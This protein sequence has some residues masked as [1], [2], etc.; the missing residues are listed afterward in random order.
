M[1]TVV[2]VDGCRAGWFAVALD[3]QGGW[4]VEV[5]SG[6]LELWEEHRGAAHI[7]VDIPI[8]LVSG[9]PMERICDR[10]AR[11]LLGFPRRTSVFPAPCR[12]ALVASDHA[13]ANR[14]NRTRT[15]R[16]LSIQAWGIVPSIVEVDRVL[17]TRP[18]AR[19]VIREVHPELLFWA[20][21]AE[22]SMVRRKKSRE[23]F[24]E[25]SAVL[26]RTNPLSDLISEHALARWPRKAVAR[27]D[28]L[29]ALAAA[30]SAELAGEGLETVPENP[31]TDAEGLPMEIIYVRPGT[32]RSN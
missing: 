12:A 13:E 32:D 31:P 11:S 9:G 18:D 4:E 22:T 2:G 20:L 7:F 3:G 17:K 1:R 14:I 21:N 6:F 23:G 28:I 15:G 25:R 30:V 27:D 26:R 8:G 24:E 19:P 29:D 10:E 5:F 16:G